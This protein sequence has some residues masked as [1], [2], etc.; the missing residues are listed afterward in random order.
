MNQ[1]GTPVQPSLVVVG[2]DGSA[3]A[4]HALRWAAAEARLRKVRLRVVHAWT[5]GFTGIPGGG[6]GYMGDSR[7]LSGEGI[8]ELRRAAEELLDRAITEIATEARG[9]EIERQ[10]IEGGAAEVL[11]GAATEGDLLVV[12]SRGHG[13]LAGLLL[14]S[15]SQQC[16]HHAS[17]PVVIVRAP[18]TSA[19]GSMST[20]VAPLQR[21]RREVRSR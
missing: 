11:V 19:S 14:G 13:G 21:E 18:R 17:C 15:I 12:G 3:G 4:G 9:I 10:V 8:S 6:Y 7:S 2:V 20:G 16:A 1:N 5:I